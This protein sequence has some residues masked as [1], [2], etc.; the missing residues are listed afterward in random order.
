[1]LLVVLTM[2]RQ[3]QHMLSQYIMILR[4]CQGDCRT[5]TR[6]RVQIR[7]VGLRKAAIRKE[8]QIR[9]DLCTTGVVVLEVCSDFVSTMFIIVIGHLCLYYIWGMGL[10]GGSIQRFISGRTLQH[11]D[12]RRVKKSDLGSIA[13][14]LR[15]QCGLW[16]D[17]MNGCS[18]QDLRA[19]FRRDISGIT[20]PSTFLLISTDVVKLSVVERMT[21]SLLRCSNTRY[22]PSRA[23]LFLLSRFLFQ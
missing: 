19:I 20:G 17:N 2:R 13:G 18:L 14:N 6:N 22:S 12:R 11:G 9:C 1:M 15:V 10:M 7:P 16:I 5:D 3:I 4:R 23:L 21:Y 8:Q